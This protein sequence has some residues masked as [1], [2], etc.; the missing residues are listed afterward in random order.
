MSEDKRITPEEI[1]RLQELSNMMSEFRK[2][3]GPRK[4]AII[5]S[6]T[7]TLPIDEILSIMDFEGKTNCSYNFEHNEKPYTMKINLR[8]MA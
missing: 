8:K 6:L 7:T 4:E 2:T 5:K 1:K 3:L